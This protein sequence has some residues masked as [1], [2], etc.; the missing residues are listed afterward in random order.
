M[1]KFNQSDIQA[2]LKK[3]LWGLLTTT[4]ALV[5]GW[6]S[7]VLSSH[8]VASKSASPD[9]SSREERKSGSSV[10]TFVSRTQN[11]KP[12]MCLGVSVLRAL[13]PAPAL[14]VARVDDQW[15]NCSRSLK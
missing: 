5:G 11:V 8:T 4:A 15:R 2:A 1:S 3:G 10:E 14:L 9:E 12:P 6:F 13:N 7:H